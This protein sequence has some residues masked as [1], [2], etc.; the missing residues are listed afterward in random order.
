MHWRQ[1][2][3]S[4]SMTASEN[5]WKGLVNDPLNDLVN[6]QPLNRDVNRYLGDRQNYNVNRLLNIKGLNRLLDSNRQFTRPFKAP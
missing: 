6:M 1:R 2:V 3:P 4:K 5:L